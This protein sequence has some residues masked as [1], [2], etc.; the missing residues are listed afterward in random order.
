MPFATYFI[1][2]P[3]TISAWLSVISSDGLS[4]KRSPTNFSSFIKYSSSFTLFINM[5]PVSSKNDS[6]LFG[7]DF[8]SNKKTPQANTC[9]GRIH[10]SAVPP[11]FGITSALLSTG[12][13]ATHDLMLFLYNGSIRWHLPD[14]HRSAHCSKTG[15]VLF[16]ERLTPAAFSLLCPDTCYFLSSLLDIIIYKY[17]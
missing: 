17:N 12:Y 5:Y 9:L 3:R 7:Q 16:R 11:N 13:C 10:P 8:Q 1:Y 6:W 2:P 14:S 4:L 15:S